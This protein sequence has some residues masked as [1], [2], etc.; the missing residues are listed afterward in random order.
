MLVKDFKLQIWTADRQG[1]AVGLDAQ[2]AAQTSKARPYELENGDSIAFVNLSGDAGRREILVKD[3]YTISGSTTTSSKL[4]WK[5]EGQT[6]HF[7]YPFDMDGDG[8]DEILDRLLAVGPHRP[9]A[10]EPRHELKDHADA[11]RW[12]ISAAI[13]T[14]GPRVMLAAATRA[15]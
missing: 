3:R 14:A 9:A 11:S 5:G 6:G 2:D 7:P 13:P 10:L 4:L 15:S 1:E 12:A 8:R